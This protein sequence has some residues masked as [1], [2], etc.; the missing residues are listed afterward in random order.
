MPKSIQ[1]SFTPSENADAVLHVVLPR[2]DILVAIRVYESALA[3]LV[4]LLEVAGVNSVLLSH[5]SL[6]IKQVILELTDVGSVR[7]R[8]IVGSLS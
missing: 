6:P 8:E 4:A 2:A 7:V 5:L 3:A 1:L